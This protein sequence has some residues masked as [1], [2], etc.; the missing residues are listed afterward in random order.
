MRFTAI[1]A[2]IRLRSENIA[3]LPKIIT[4]I[5]PKGKLEATDHA[6]YKLLKYKPNPWMNVFSFWEYINACMDGW[7]NAYILVIRSRGGIPSEL[8]PIHPSFVTPLVRKSGESIR[9]WYIVAS[10]MPYDGTYPDEEMLH[11]FSFSKD[12]IQGVNPILYN[13]ASIFSVVSAQEFANE[14]FSSGGSIKGTLETDKLLDAPS[15]AD[16]MT[17]FNTSKNFGTPLLDQGIKYKQVGISPEAA[18][19]IETRTFALQD[20]AR[21]FNVPPHLLADL[22]RAT[23]SNIEHQDI[24][25]VKYALRP[26]VKRYETELQTKLL[27]DDEMGDHEIK[28]N[29][30]GLLRGDTATRSVFYHNAILDGWMS[31]N[32]VREMENLN[33]IENLD[34]MLY[35]SNE[36][37]AGQQLEKETKN[38]K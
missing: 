15:M 7:G 22:S 8:I 20:I 1:F 9:K 29:L 38:N 33:Q 6:V 28:F 34:E 37:I 19:M 30:D 18:Q 5:T 32:E 10:G 25:F 2:A 31:R 3:S 13:A 24:Q 27:F 14:F 11:F 17:K 12:G 4:R 21:I 35:P 23:F 16:V 26:S 36:R